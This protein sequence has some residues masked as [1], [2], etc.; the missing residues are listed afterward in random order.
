[1]MR[2]V[3]RWN[4]WKKYHS[5]IGLDESE[6]ERLVCADVVASLLQILPA[7]TSSR[8]FQFAIR[9]DSIRFVMRIDSNRFV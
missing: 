8:A 3:S 1:M 2:V 9:I 5:V 7:Q 6:M 4:R